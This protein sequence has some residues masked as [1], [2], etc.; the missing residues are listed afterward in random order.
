MNKTSITK[1]FRKVILH[2]DS[3]LVQ[4]AFSA[5]T[6]AFVDADDIEGAM[7]DE[8]SKEELIKLI[9]SACVKQCLRLI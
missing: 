9:E 6:S 5:E 3:R 1:C 4:P 7:D 2:K 8:L